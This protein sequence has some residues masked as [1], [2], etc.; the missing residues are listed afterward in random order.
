MYSLLHKKQLDLD[1]S[2]NDCPL[3]PHDVGLIEIFLMVQNKSRLE[4]DSFR[5]SVL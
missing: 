1:Q 4:V 5:I 2:E 3:S